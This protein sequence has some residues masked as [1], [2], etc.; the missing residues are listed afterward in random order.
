LRCGHRLQ[1]VEGKGPFPWSAER[2]RRMNSTPEEFRRTLEQAFGD[3]VTIDETGLLLST[4]DAV[5]HYA[6]SCDAPYRI[7]MIEVALLRVEISVRRGDERAAST[8]Q[9]HVD[10][11]TQRGGG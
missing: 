4:D 1:V 8:L 10:R 2:I 9:A 3:A 11:A 5:L 6:L 7:G